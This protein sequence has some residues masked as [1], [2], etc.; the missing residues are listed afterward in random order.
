M[1]YKKII[2]LFLVL[3]MMLSM[4]GSVAANDTVQITDEKTA[5]SFALPDII[6]ADEARENAYVAR[7]KD[8]E[9][10]LN[11]LVF[12][13]EDGSYTMRLFDIPVKYEDK[14]GK[15]QDITTD[16]K[17][18]KDGS[19]QTAQNSIITTFSKQLV[20]GVNLKYEDINITLR[21]E[22]SAKL[23]ATASMRDDKTVAY[24]LNA[25]TALSY[26]LTY[27]GFKEDIVVAEY[28][29][30][31]EYPFVIETN[32]LHPIQKGESWYLADDDNN[33][34]ANIGDVIIFTADEQNNAFGSMK[35]ETI[36]EN[37]SYRLTICVDADYLKDPKTK[38]PIRIDPTIEINSGSGAIAD[39]T[40]SS[41]AESDGS[42]G[43]LY[44]GLRQ[45]QGKTRIL[46]KFP[47]LSLGNIASASNITSAK[48]QMRDLMCESTSSTILVYPFNGNDWN[49][50]SSHW[51]TVNPDAFVTGDY[52][53]YTTVRY[54][55]GATLSPIHRYSWDITAIV[56]AW[57]SGVSNVVQSKGIMFKVNNA[58]EN[59]GTYAHRTFA[60]FNRSS[61]KP[62]VSVTYTSSGSGGT[63]P[64]VT[65]SGIFLG[66]VYGTGVGINHQY[67]GNEEPH[68]EH[69]DDLFSMRDTIEQNNS[70][71]DD[72][73]V[74]NCENGFY[75]KSQVLGF[76]NTADDLFFY[77]GHGHVV[78]ASLGVTGIE[79]DE[80]EELTN[81]NADAN[82]WG[83]VLTNQ[84]I[85]SSYDLS[86][87][88]IAGLIACLTAYSPP[89]LMEPSNLPYKMYQAGAECV[90]G[91]TDPIL[92]GPAGSWS[93]EFARYLTQDYSV[94][95]ICKALAKED[96]YVNGLLHHYVIYGDSTVTLG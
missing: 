63:T 17:A 13:N 70:N 62:S 48:V 49:E 39:M 61:Y 91:F 38:Y 12:L 56:K 65:K 72:I 66:I 69:D 95:A 27:T 93:E 26:S 45:T 54:S 31:T 41:N 9:D 4:T 75:T 19:F 23:T 79:I 6:D 71:Y 5:Q 82:D 40:I 25:K 76:M 51:S 32:G 20:Q 16:I 81:P 84:D 64:P 60:S 58:T 46:M 18:L 36:E 7:A 88:K 29:G 33:I 44:V 14:D 2:S 47:G 94:G 80:S 34:K 86:N 21:P 22:S 68:W 15:I 92:C 55:K 37:K 67:P 85:T 50:S 77:R 87:I 59:S 30:Q 11:T 43:S 83:I 96:D 53:T 78:N 90:F 28:T 74:E 3:A 10:N 1:R 35:V 89:N 73:V 24:M 52:D 42:S 57:K 8:Q